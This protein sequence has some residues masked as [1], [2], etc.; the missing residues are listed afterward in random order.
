MMTLPKSPVSQHPRK[1][2]SNFTLIELLVVIG[3][4]AVL[5]SLLLPALSSAKEQAYRIQCVGNLKQLGAAY[6]LYADDNGGWFPVSLYHEPYDKPRYGRGQ[7]ENEWC[8]VQMLER[9]VTGEYTS[10]GQ[11]TAPIMLAPGYLV[12]DSFKCPKNWKVRGIG[13]SYLGDDWNEGW[14]AIAGFVHEWLAT[15]ISEAAYEAAHGVNVNRSNYE[16]SYCLPSGFG[17]KGDGIPRYFGA[18]KASG[19]PALPIAADMYEDYIGSVVV[20]GRHMFQSNS[21]SADGSVY[22]FRTS[23]RHKTDDPTMKVYQTTGNEYVPVFDG[24]KDQL[25]GDHN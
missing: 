15:H 14:R 2:R 22:S 18:L 23:G 13:G 19:N 8:R 6:H 5:A 9:E 4:I 7:Y 16:I 25:R 1:S 11:L 20:G 12:P 24:D 3:I 17:K 10:N 21:V